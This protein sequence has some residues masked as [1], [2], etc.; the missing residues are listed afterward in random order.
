MI[1]LFL[2]RF[3]YRTERIRKSEK[4]LVKQIGLIIIKARLDMFKWGSF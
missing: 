2:F 1:Y 4:K 3:M